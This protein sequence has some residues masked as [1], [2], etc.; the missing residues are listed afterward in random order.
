MKAANPAHGGAGKASP[1]DRGD[2]AHQPSAER[3][4]RALADEIVSGI[5]APG[6]RLEEQSLAD[7]FEVSRTPVREAFRQLGAA[8]LVKI[9]PHKSVIVTDIDVEELQELFEA[10]ASV[11]YLL[12]RFASR[13]MSTMERLRLQHIHDA[14]VKAHQERDHDHYAMLN[15]DFH[16]LIYRGSRNRHL[17]AIAESLRLRLGPFRST[18]FRAG[19]RMDSSIRE[20]AAI[21]DAILDEDAEAAG[22]A[23]RAHI[24]SSSVNAMRFFMQSRGAGSGEGEPRNGSGA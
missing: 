6:T 11:E 12:A 20:H 19:G 7:R 22:V 16:S 15:H 3:V 13:R 8:G 18:S 21:V 2:P 10:L 17:H 23:L 14:C 4:R 5:L 9:R 1:S 24:D